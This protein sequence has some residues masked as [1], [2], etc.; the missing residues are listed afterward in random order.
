MGLEKHTNTQDSKVQRVGTQP[1]DT[2]SLVTGSLDFEKSENCVEKI[3][4]EVGMGF[5]WPKTWAAW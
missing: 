5:V 3:G 1:F 4:F 2:A